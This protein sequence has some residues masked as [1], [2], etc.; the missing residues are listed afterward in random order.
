V[1]WLTIIVN[2]PI[3]AITRSIQIFSLFGS[4]VQENAKLQRR[5]VYVT[6]YLTLWIGSWIGTLHLL[7]PLLL[8]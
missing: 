7:N 1:P 4:L 5:T 8:L 3:L 2:T 6:P